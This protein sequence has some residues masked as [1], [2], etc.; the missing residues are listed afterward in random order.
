[1][2]QFQIE[3]DNCKKYISII[4]IDP[5]QD[6]ECQYCN[7]IQVVPESQTSQNEIIC[8]KCS[9]NQKQDA[10]YCHK[11]GESLFNTQLI[12]YCKECDSEYT[13]NDEFQYCN[14]DGKKLFTKEKRIENTPEPVK[15]IIKRTDKKTS[16]SKELTF[17]LGN[18]FIAICFIQSA[19][20][21]Y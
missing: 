18:F 17:A 4:N 13:D 1:M 12:K 16:K 20:A 5:G 14:K 10:I 3:C 8:R 2:T 15:I 9:T 21:L 11:C 6:V 7:N 19:A